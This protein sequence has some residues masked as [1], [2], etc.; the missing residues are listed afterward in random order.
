MNTHLPHHHSS[1][2]D[3]IISIIDAVEQEWSYVNG[4]YLHHIQIRVPLKGD[5]EFKYNP[6]Q[7]NS[8]IRFLSNHKQSINCLDNRAWWSSLF[9]G[10]SYK[11]SIVQTAPESSIEVVY[12]IA[13]L[14]RSFDISI[15][16]QFT[17]RASKI[18]PGVVIKLLS[19]L[20]MDSQERFQRA[21]SF[22]LNQNSKVSLDSP[23][24]NS[25]EKN[26][27]HWV[28]EAI[29]KKVRVTGSLYKLLHQP[30]NLRRL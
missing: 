6:A 21:I 24:V 30:Y 15:D 18:F 22:V 10:A 12:D 19:S 4:K 29:G 2:P 27:K 28:L 23:A 17:L 14:S 7:L 13:C 16:E 25:L 8:L 9:E 11:I 1:L 26:L 20:L 3:K 5:G